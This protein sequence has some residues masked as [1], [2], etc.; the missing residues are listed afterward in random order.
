[1]GYLGRQ[2]HVFLFDHRFAVFSVRQ[3]FF[4]DNKLQKEKTRTEASADQLSF[5]T[6]QMY[7]MVK[8]AVL[9]QIY[10]TPGL[11]D[12]CSGRLRDNLCFHIW[13][14]KAIFVRRNQVLSSNN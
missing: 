13:V 6:Y 11:W 12:D 7:D 5:V 2:T 10:A 14:T 9:K 1:M 4:I 3:N 8:D